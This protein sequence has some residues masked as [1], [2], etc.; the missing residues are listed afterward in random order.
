MTTAEKR[1]F[2]KEVAMPVLQTFNDTRAIA[3]LEIGPD[4][5]IE[6]AWAHYFHFCWEAREQTPVDKPPGTA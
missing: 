5:I 2:I 3:L 4:E 6:Y 1:A